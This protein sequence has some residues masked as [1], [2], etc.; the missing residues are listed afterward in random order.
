MIQTSTIRLDTANFG[1]VNPFPD[2]KN[3]GY[4]HAG[5]H[6]EPEI[7]EE[8]RRYIGHGMITT[9]LPYLQQDGYDRNKSPRDIDVV[10]LENNRLRATFMPHLGGRLRSLYDLKQER[11][12]LYV[13]SVLQ[14]A[15]FALRNAWFSGGVE[16]NIGIKG[17]SPLTCSPL[18]CEIG[19]G[20]D[21]LRM[22]GYERIRGVAYCIEA[23]LPEESDVLYIR[24]TV[25]NSSENEVPMYWWSNIA[26]PEHRDTRVIVPADDAIGCLYRENHYTL[27]KTSIPVT[28]APPVGVDVSYPAR[29]PFSA[30]YFYK[31]PKSSEKWIAAVDENGNG[32]LQFSDEK[33]AG[34]KL[35]IWGSGNGGRRWNEFLSERGQ[36]Y[37]EIQ[38]GLATTQM[39]HLPMPAGE[40]W[41]WTEGYTALACDP[42]AV[43]GDF[44]D[45]IDAVGAQLLTHPI[46]G[47]ALSRMPFP[48]EYKPLSSGDG[49]GG[50]EVRVR[51]LT[52]EKPLH[53]TVTF[54][55]LRDMETKPWHTLLDGGI[56]SS[57]DPTAAPTSYV[58]GVFWRDA[59]LQS[60]SRPN[61]KNWY[62]LV[63][64]GVIL[65]ALGDVSGAEDAWRESALL[66]PNVWAY[67]NLA[68][69]YK[70]EYGKNEDAYR[71]M[72]D[73]ASLHPDFRAFHIEYASTLTETGHDAEWL[74]YYAKLSEH[75]KQNG[76]IRFF[77]ALAY[78]H[79]GQAEEAAAIITPSFEMCDVKEGELYLSGLWF[80][81]YTEIV[82]KRDGTDAKTAY[83]TAQIEYPLP[84]T[85]DF[86]MH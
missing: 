15:N 55:E 70:N 9:M 26:V 38:A 58:T 81:I 50:L 27:G 1:E 19:E 10:I 47:G 35:F 48:T 23:Y 37:I 72:K 75:H 56:L 63:H 21:A 25:E 36:A 54:P 71:Y 33:L 51:S 84:Y 5:Y 65:Y 53:T 60:Y 43:H 24:T 41:Q 42:D 80:D 34:R 86:R 3:I 4:I 59:V 64:L 77:V 78:L 30:D 73:A 22:Y 79:L 12:L 69:L 44:H 2:I 28:D 66:T 49:W 20:G 17:H 68:M 74:S 57:D 61:G 31:V 18:F 52:G 7:S 8:E 40:I 16:F 76:R 6:L 85:L 82:K 67:R 13:N 46:H 32:L 29:L 83:E 62:S 14:P 45:A 11:E 39:E